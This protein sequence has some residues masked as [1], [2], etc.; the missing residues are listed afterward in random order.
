[1][2]IGILLGSVLGG[3]LIAAASF[4]VL[5][6]AAAAVALAGAATTRWAVT[7]TQDEAR[8]HQ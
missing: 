6:E 4:Q 2:H 3:R 8:Q 5:I 7:S 1:M